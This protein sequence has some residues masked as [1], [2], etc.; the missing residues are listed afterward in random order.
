MGR[1]LRREAAHEQGL[2]ARGHAGRG[3]F[4]HPLLGRLA[5]R[6][7]AP[8][9]AQQAGQGLPQGLAVARR[10]AHGPAAAGQPRPEGAELQRLGEL[11]IIR[12]Q[13]LDLYLKSLSRFSPS[14]LPVRELAAYPVNTKALL[15]KYW[16]K[17]SL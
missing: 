6:R 2:E 4:G 8:G 7:G 10:H 13:L 3:E 16:A 12:Q 1:S 9:I 5:E 17:L 14:T 15:R 11:P